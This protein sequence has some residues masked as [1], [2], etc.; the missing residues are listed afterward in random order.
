MQRL[1]PSFRFKLLLAGAFVAVLW[2]VAGLEF[3]V[4][5]SWS[6]W[7][8]YPR[9]LDGLRGILFMPFLH[10]DW[11]HLLSNSAPA[12]VLT[13]VLL[14]RYE[15]IGL[16]VFALS[17]VLAG[18]GTWLIGRPSYHIGASALVYALASFIF[19]AGA[20]LKD[21]ASLA[22]SLFVVLWYGGL[23]WGVFPDGVEPGTSWEGHLAGAL[24][25][26]ALAT[27][28]FAG[29]GEARFERDEEDPPFLDGV[30]DE[31]I[32]TWFADR[33]TDEHDGPAHHPAK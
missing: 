24:S 6:D 8:V 28:Y 21:Q 22:M 9:R 29:R 32:R 3:A 27:V 7:G 2:M 19:F 18:L 10:G 11:D 4:G 33:V 26:L 30:T 15:R 17:L 14:V 31:D 12:F 25:G 5:A 16:Q 13:L 23:V 20:W 1:T